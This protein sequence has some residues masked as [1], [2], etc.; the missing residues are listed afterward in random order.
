[1]RWCFLVPMANLGT[2]DIEVREQPD[3]LAETTHL[4]GADSAR[5]RV[6][7]VRELENTAKCVHTG[8][9]IQIRRF[10]YVVTMS[11]M[12]EWRSSMSSGF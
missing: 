10:S 2:R 12:L 8:L 3:V 7:V 4:M 11:V 1:V 9:M 5:V 6:G